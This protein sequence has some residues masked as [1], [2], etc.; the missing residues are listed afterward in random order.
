M[1]VRLGRGHSIGTL[2]VRGDKEAWQVAQL[3]GPRTHMFSP[4]VVVAGLRNYRRFPL[5]PGHD[6]RGSGVSEV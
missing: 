5:A 4:G 6:R 1:R 3:G 2:K